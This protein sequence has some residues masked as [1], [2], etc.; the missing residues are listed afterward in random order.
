MVGHFASEGGLTD[1]PLLFPGWPGILDESCWR[2]ARLWSLVSE[3]VVS[4]EGF[5]AGPLLLPGLPGIPAPEFCPPL[6]AVTWLPPEGAVVCAEAGSATI[7]SAVAPM[8]NLNMANS[9]LMWTKPEACRL[10]AL[11]TVVHTT[12]F[13]P[14]FASKMRPKPAMG[15]HVESSSFHSPERRDSEAFPGGRPPVLSCRSPSL[16]GRHRSRHEAWLSQNRGVNLFL[17]TRRQLLANRSLQGSRVP[18]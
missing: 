5:T 17:G 15:Q 12:S 16:D 14:A 6:G 13:R 4:P 1:G 7:A 3:P 11:Q 2:I 9:L 18:V 10:Y 8:S